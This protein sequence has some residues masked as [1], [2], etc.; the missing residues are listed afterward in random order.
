MAINDVLKGLF[1]GGAELWNYQNT[2]DAIDEIGTDLSGGFADLAG[3]AR[4]NSSFTPFAITGSGG[5]AQTTADESGNYTGLNLNVNDATKA[6]VDAQRLAA[7]NL[8]T[9]AGGTLGAPTMGAASGAPTLGGYGTAG[10]LSGYGTAGSLLGYGD[11]PTLGGFGAQPT[12][13]AYGQGPTLGA[14]P[15]LQGNIGALPGAPGY[16]TPGGIGGLPGAIGR[17]GQ[18]GLFEAQQQ[19]AQYNQGQIAAGLTQGVGAGGNAIRSQLGIGTGRSEADIFGMLEGM[20]EPGRE[21][22][23]LQLRDELAG[24]GRLGVSTNQYGGT[25]EELA[26]AKAVEES[27]SANAFRSFQLAGEEQNR[28]AQQG[29]SAYGIGEQAASRQDQGLLQSFGLGNSSQQTANSLTQALGSLGLQGRQIG[30][31]FN[32]GQQGNMINQRG[33]DIQAMVSDQAN[34]NQFNLGMFGQQSA[35]VMD[36]ARIQQGADQLRLQGQGQKADQLLQMFSQTS[37]NQTAN[38]QLLA[39]LSGQSDARTMDTNR[40]MTQLFGMESGNVTAANQAANQL[41]GIQSDNITA[42]NQASNQL[43]DIQSGNVSAANQAAANIFNTQQGGVNASNAAAADM[44]ASQVRQAGQQ[45]QLADSMFRSSFLPEEN[46]LDQFG[47]GAD[48]YEVAQRGAI[49]GEQMAQ[50]ATANQLDAQYNTASLMATM[51]QN[52]N[53]QLVDMALGKSQAEGGLGEGMFDG[54]FDAAGNWISNLFN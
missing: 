46:M 9:T 37:G 49:Q 40:L 47:L 28:I 45:G 1:S 23:R 21:R 53:Q 14:I 48:M 7:G 33:Q 38:N 27:R 35:N 44:F 4:T 17:E 32:L 15:Q 2:A 10:T 30:N 13:G 19:A 20:Q 42:G 39:Q 6:A 52:R 18:T 50:N 8:Y 43:F 41:F 24:Q 11:S 54:I 31:T 3:E 25:P 51:D 22:D 36:Q 5:T 29:L 12:L 16:Q 34:A 26:R